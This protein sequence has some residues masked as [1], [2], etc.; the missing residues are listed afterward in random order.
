MLDKVLHYLLG[1]AIFTRRETKL[2]GQLKFRI[3]RRYFN[4]CAAN[5]DT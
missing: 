3:E 4:T 5:V 1:G 2:F